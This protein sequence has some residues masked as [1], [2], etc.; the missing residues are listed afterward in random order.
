M[1]R[2]R[3]TLVRVIRPE[4]TGPSRSEAETPN[5]SRRPSTSSTTASATTSLPTGVGRTWSNS[6]LTPTVV[7]PS[8]RTGPD[9]L[10]GRLLAEG[11][12]SRGPQDV[13]RARPQSPGGVGLGHDQPHHSR[14]PVAAS[15]TP[16]LTRVTDRPDR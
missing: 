16:T 14:M 3:S 6:T 1:N 9:R 15:T 13:H 2:S 4:P 11:Y 7:V 8:G 10:D 12:Q 5:T